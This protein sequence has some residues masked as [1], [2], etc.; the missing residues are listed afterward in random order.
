[1]GHRRDEVDRQSYK[2]FTAREIRG[3]GW[4]KLGK[5]GSGLMRSTEGRLDLM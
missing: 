4:L 3:G 2:L 1:M 5:K